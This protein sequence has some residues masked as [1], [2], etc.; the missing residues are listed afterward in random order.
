MQKQEALFLRQ[1]RHNFVRIVL[2]GAP[3]LLCLIELGHPVLDTTN[4]FRMLSPI[5]IWWIIMH[6]MIAPLFALMGWALWLLLEG[7]RGPIAWTS[8]VAASTFSV[9]AIGYEF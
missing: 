9:F 2:F 3:F 5:V 8:R 1:R 4:T 7:I 6:I